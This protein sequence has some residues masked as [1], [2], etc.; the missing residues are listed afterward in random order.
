M[1]ALFLPCGAFAAQ[2][3]GPVDVTDLIVWDQ[4]Y[5]NVIVSPYKNVGCSDTQGYQLLQ[6]AESEHFNRMYSLLLAA[7]TS[8]QKVSF[9]I[10]GCGTKGKIK[11]LSFTIPASS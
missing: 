11:A 1:L 10:D 6:T 5:V 2:W 3:T 7:H 8:K 4:T 9:L